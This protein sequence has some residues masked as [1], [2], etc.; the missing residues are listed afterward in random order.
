[1]IRFGGASPRP[2]AALAADLS[3]LLPTRFIVPGFSG[4]ERRAVFFEERTMNV[5]PNERTDTNEPAPDANEEGQTDGDIPG[6][7]AD[8]GRC[9]VDRLAE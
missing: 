8:I 6:C 4:R 5:E 7:P 9:D 3:R 1:M 2:P